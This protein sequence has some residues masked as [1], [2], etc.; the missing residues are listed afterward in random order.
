MKIRAI[1][2]YRL[3]EVL[4]LDYLGVYRSLQE[5]LKALFKI[6]GMLV[7]QPIR[8]W[9]LELSALA[10]G[11]L[12]LHPLMTLAMLAALPDLMQWTNQGNFLKSL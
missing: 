6:G 4:D 7:V 1:S 10:F 11:K 5:S 12:L 9:G 3:H 8:G 2:Q